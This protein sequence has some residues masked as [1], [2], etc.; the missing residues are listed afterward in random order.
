MA[1]GTIRVTS[2]A[3]GIAAVRISASA[4][5]VERALGKLSQASGEEGSFGGEAAGGAFGTMCGRAR[6]ALGEIQSTAQ[7]LSTNTGA[8]AQGYLVTDQGVIHTSFSK[9]A[10]LGDG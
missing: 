8:A 7:E 1:G 3:L 9:S 10:E 2:D 6:S 4:D 5:A